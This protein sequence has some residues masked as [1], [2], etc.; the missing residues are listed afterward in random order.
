VL[1]TAATEWNFPRQSMWVRAGRGG[2]KTVPDAGVRSD[3]A[4]EKHLVLPCGTTMWFRHRTC[5]KTVLIRD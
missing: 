2:T 3:A 1:P 5:L 4:E